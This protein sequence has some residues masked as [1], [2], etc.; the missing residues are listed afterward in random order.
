MKPEPCGKHK[1]PSEKSAKKGKRGLFATRADSG[2]K[3][4]PHAY[5]CRDCRAWHVGH[6]SNS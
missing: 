1:Y 6:S 3:G 2:Y 4:R 5:F